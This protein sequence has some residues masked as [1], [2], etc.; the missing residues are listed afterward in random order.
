MFNSYASL[1]SRKLKKGAHTPFFSA[2]TLYIGACVMLLVHAL[3]IVH[4]AALSDFLHARTRV[5]ARVRV[6]VCNMM[7]I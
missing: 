7:Y 5:C 4:A 3:Q 2:L 1:G 6:C